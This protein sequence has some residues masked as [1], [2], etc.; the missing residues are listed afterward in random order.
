VLHFGA[1]GGA[2][3]QV[4]QALLCSTPGFAFAIPCCAGAR[5]RMELAVVVALAPAGWRRAGGVTSVFEAICA[6]RIEAI[7]SS[8]S[9]LLRTCKI[10]RP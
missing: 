10:K 9:T 5:R 2:A 6:T 1:D 7:W 8:N 3:A 4:Y